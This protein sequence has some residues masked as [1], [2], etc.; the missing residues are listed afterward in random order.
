MKTY[1]LKNGIN[2]LFLNKNNS[3][4]TLIGFICKTGFTDEYKN[5]PNGITMLIERLFQKGTHKNPSVK[6]I[7]LA[8]EQI[9]ARWYSETDNETTSYFLLVPQENQFKAVSLMAE[10]IQKS[11][12]D[13]KDIEDSKLEMIEEVKS[14]RK[15][16]NVHFG[17]ENLYTCF[18]YSQKKIGS[19]DQIM[20][21]NQSTILDYLSRQYRPNNCY[22][23]VS[24]NFQQKALQELIEQEWMYWLPT[25]RKSED[26]YFDSTVCRT[27][28]P[29]IPFLQSAKL[30]TDI[31]INFLSKEGLIPFELSD[32]NNSVEETDLPQIW[33]NYIER[34]AI[35]MLINE[36][37]IGGNTGKLYLKTDYDEKLVNHIQS[38]YLSFTQSSALSIYTN[39]DNQNFNQTLDVILSTFNDLKRNVITLNEMQKIKE[40][41]KLNLLVLKCDIVYSTLFYAKHFILAGHTFEISDILTKINY[42]DSTQLR[43]FILDLFNVKNLSLSIIGTNKESKLIEK[44]ISKYLE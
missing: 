42:I 36:L 10:I 15:G 39:V 38:E 29:K 11:Y 33:D 1:C 32:N 37:L 27:D 31:N 30:D 44:L 28:L 22:I 8:I 18:S 2:T 16:V 23:T 40:L 20:S 34:Y 25:V 21:I 9:G 17:L 5:F 3:D 13:E 6:K 4:L 12:F 19:I 24:G 7:W 14:I 26:Q 43:T 35:Y 41:T